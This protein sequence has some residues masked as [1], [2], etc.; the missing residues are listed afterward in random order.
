LPEIVQALDNCGVSYEM[1]KLNLSRRK[2]VSRISV[3]ECGNMDMEWYGID[4]KGNVA[5]F[6]SGGEGNLPEFVCE[7]VERADE[8]I[9]YFDRMKKITGSVLM[10]PKTKVGRAEQVVLNILI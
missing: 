9:E 5:V 8:L 7:N 2:I 6:C 1:L 10:F 3:G 4:K